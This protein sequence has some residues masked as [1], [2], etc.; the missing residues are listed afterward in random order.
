MNDNFVRPNTEWV[1]WYQ[2][3]FDRDTPRRVELAGRGWLAG[4]IE[5][6]ARH[7]FEAVQA[8]GERGFSRFNLWLPQTEKSIIVV[9]DWQGQVRLRR[10]IYGDRQLT[11]TG[12]AEAGDRELLQSVASAH[13]NLILEGKTSGELL[14][15]AAGVQNRADFIGRLSQVA[16]PHSIAILSAPGC[17][18][19]ETPWAWVCLGTTFPPEREKHKHGGGSLLEHDNLEEYRDPVNYDIEDSSDDRGSNTHPGA[20]QR[21]ARWPFRS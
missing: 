8:N 11:D 3:L 4:L 12:Y 14:A 5:L 6:W 1:L 21:M 17:V 18:I 13:R 2:D 10:W 15:W 19:R 7:L 16:Y 20:F 9:G